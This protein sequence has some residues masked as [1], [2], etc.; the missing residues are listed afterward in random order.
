MRRTSNI[1]FGQVVEQ[2]GGSQLLAIPS[3]YEVVSEELNNE[4][5]EALEEERSDDS[6]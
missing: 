2:A 3:M 1:G 5:L 4:V 6:D